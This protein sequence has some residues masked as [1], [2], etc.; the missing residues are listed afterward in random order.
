MASEILTYGL[1]SVALV[2]IAAVII[3]GLK[4]KGLSSIMEMFKKKKEEESKVKLEEITAKE[5]EV[6]IKITE[7]EKK[8]EQQKEV[9]KHIAQEAQ[10]KVDEALKEKDP[11]KLSQML[12]K[13][14]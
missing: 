5:A 1:G 2:S 11:V 9:I 12:D 4:G 7:A 8:S 10:K 13:E 6:S 3:S 14:W